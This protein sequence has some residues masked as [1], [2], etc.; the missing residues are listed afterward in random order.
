M[1]KIKGLAKFVLAFAFASL[2]SCA[3][4]GGGGMKYLVDPTNAATYLTQAL[5]T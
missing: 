4:M 2:A 5:Q 1:H 3:S